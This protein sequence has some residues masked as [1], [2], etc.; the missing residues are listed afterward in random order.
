[1]AFDILLEVVGAH[2]LDPHVWFHLAECCMLAHQPDNNNQGMAREVS[3]G[4]AGAGLSY[5]LVATNPP[6]P[7][8]GSSNNPGATPVLSMDFAYVCLKNAE[9]LLP[10]SG[11][12]GEGVF[13]EG[14]GYI[15]NPITWVEVEQLRV[16]IITCKA[17]TALS[18]GDYVPAQH[19]A[20]E[21]LSQ[22]QAPLAGCYQLL[23]HLYAA[24]SLILQ[25]RLVEAMVHLDPDKVSLGDT[26][27]G[28]SQSL[29]H[30]W[31]PDTLE[32]GKQAVQYNLAV[33][34]ALRE[35]WDKSSS[36]VGQL[37]KEGKDVPVQVGRI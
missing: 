31:Y 32:M 22:A 7:L 13:C 6:Q 24:E 16:A 36:I 29:A 35:E 2:Y 3:Q 5:K 19:F 23:A 11:S 9:S 34:F 37:Y 18:L 33:G 17:Y 4:G 26:W 14:V 10:S 27:E 28:S 12:A 20:E 8:V 25:D 30:T 21:I 1:M 15:G